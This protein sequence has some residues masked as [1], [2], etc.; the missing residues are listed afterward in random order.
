MK[1]RLSLAGL[2]LAA[3][4]AAAATPALPPASFSA[5]FVQTREV[6][7]FATPLVSHGNMSYDKAKGFHWEINQPF[8]YLFEMNGKQAHEE[9][10]DGTQRDLDPDQTP[11]LAAV[12]HIF[13]SALS[14]DRHELESYFS[15]ESKPTGSGNQLTLTPKP[16]PI[17]NA[18]KRI[19]VTESAPGRPQHLEIFENSGGHLDIRFTPTAP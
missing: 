3:G 6:Q 17:G 10:P 7:G 13:I 5:S 12:E 18:I 9:L 19:E 16:G 15:V 8:H 2:L 4:A 1:M 11:W 14:G